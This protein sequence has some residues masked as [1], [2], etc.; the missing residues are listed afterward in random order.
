M[1]FFFFIYTYMLFF[2][3][4]NSQGSIDGG[5][6]AKWKG[7]WRSSKKDKRGTDGIHE[8]AEE[9]ELPVDNGFHHEVRKWWSL[10]NLRSLLK[11]T[12][13]QNQELGLQIFH[14]FFQT[15]CYYDTF[16]PLYLQTFKSITSWKADIN[17]SVKIC[18]ISYY[19]K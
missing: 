14:S 11:F 3:K 12:G 10:L 7:N 5:A 13:K 4:G 15:I 1:T 16:L 17:G 6:E 8:R 19:I 2:W 9:G 18:S